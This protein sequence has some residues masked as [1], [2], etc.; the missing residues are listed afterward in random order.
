MDPGVLC[1]NSSL[2]AIACRAPQS[3]KDLKE[4]PELKGWFRREFG[5][6]VTEVS[7]QADAEPNPESPRPRS[8]RRGGEHKPMRH[9]ERKPGASGRQRG[10]GKPKAEK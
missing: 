10:S 2:E 8:R 7:K 6:E 9:A 5:A 1:P 4:L 3:A